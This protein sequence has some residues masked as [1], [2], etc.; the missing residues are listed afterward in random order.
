M[1]FVIERTDILGKDA[2][3]VGTINK[4]G[5]VCLDIEVEGG[6]NCLQFVTDHS[7]FDEN[8]QQKCLRATD[9]Q[10]LSSGCFRSCNRCT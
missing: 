5:Q 6:T 2:N 9:E 1:S 3:A 7:G 10:I 4:Q 8:G